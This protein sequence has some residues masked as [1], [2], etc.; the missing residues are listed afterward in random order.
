MTVVLD[1]DLPDGSVLNLGGTKLTVNANS[2]ISAGL[3]EWDLE[4][5]IRAPDWA[6]EG[7]KVTMSL[8]IPSSNAALALISLVDDSGNPVSLTPWPFDPDVAEY[9]P[10]V[11]NTSAS[12]I[13][14]A[15]AA[16]LLATVAISAGLCTFQAA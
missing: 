9:T 10:D 5:H 11:P 13:L 2:R 1:R 7:K 14:T 16:D 12:V 6:E 4:G 15:T 3:F 8:R